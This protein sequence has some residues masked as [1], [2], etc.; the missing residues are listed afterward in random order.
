[1]KLALLIESA[2]NQLLAEML[3]AA[4]PQLGLPVTV[5]AAEANVVIT[6]NHDYLWHNLHCNNKEVV[7]L[8]N[9]K[10]VANFRISF[11]LHA[12]RLHVFDLAPNH[13]GAADLALFLEQ[14]ARGPQSELNL[15]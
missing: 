7:Q 12:D 10:S 3:R 2:E 11:A 1:M 15:N 13:G 14:L 4:C 9:G 8:H 6:D 5:T